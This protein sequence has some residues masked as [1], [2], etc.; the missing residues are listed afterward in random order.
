MEMQVKAVTEG[1]KELL[2][3]ESGEKDRINKQSI[4]AI[5]MLVDMANQES[6]NENDKQL[7]GMEI[8]QKLSKIQADTESK[9][10]TA[11]LNSLLKLLDISIASDTGQAKELFSEV[12]GDD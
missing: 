1:Q 7:K 3:A 5:K 12:E 2:D 8:M 11:A 4:A 6:R 10:K 9:D